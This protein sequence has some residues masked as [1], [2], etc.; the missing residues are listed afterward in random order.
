MK[1]VG[2]AKGTAPA[3]S[4]GNGKKTHAPVLQETDEDLQDKL[5]VEQELAQAEE[6]E[7][8]E[9]HKKQ[10]PLKGFPA[11][12]EGASSFG[13]PPVSTTAT[14]ALAKASLKA[15]HRHRSNYRHR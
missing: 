5:A 4:S 3:G 12:G 15:S 13:F 9:I 11:V 1:V 7:S 6:E 8:E 10:A 14:T 2:C